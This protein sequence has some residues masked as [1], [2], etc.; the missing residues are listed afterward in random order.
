MTVPWEASN[1]V[2]FEGGPVQIPIPVSVEYLLQLD[3]DCV[4]DSF[5]LQYVG[6]GARKQAIWEISK[7]GLRQLVGS[8]RHF[9]HHGTEGSLGQRSGAL[10]WAN[11]MEQEHLR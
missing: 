8:V 5:G 10:R 9:A 1:Y 7:G 3:D 6:P 11:R 2:N 4:S